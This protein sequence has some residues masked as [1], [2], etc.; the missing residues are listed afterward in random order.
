MTP[1]EARQANNKAILQAIQ[2]REESTTATIRRLT[3]AQAVQQR[4]APHQPH[5][6]TLSPT[7]TTNS[8]TQAAANPP[9]PTTPAPNHC[10]NGDIHTSPQPTSQNPQP[11]NT[12]LAEEGWTLV[13]RKK[14]RPSHQHITKPIDHNIKRD[15]AWLLQQRRCFKCFLKGHQKQQCNRTIKCLQCNQEGHIS[16]QC[17]NRF[18]RRIFTD[19][20]TNKYVTPSA[21]GEK[22]RQF[23]SLSTGTKQGSSNFLRQQQARL[24]QQGRC[25]K[26]CLRGHTKQQCTRVV[27]CF[28]CNKDGHTT[29]RCNPNPINAQP[30]KSNPR[31]IKDNDVQSHPTQPTHRVVN[32]ATNHLHHMENTS[33]WETMDLMDPD[34][35]EDG[36][37]ESLRVFLPPRTPL[38]PINSFLERSALVLAGPHPINRYIAHRLAVTLATHFNMQPQ[39]FPIS[40]VHQNYGDFLVRFPNT[41]LRDQAV[42]ICVFTLGPN[43]HLQLVEWTPGMG[44]VYDPVTHKARLRLYGLL[45]HNWNIHDL[46]ILGRKTNSRPEGFSEWADH[47]RNFSSPAVPTRE[48]RGNGPAVRFSRPRIPGN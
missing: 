39:D 21:K 9:P 2:K 44:G 18:N 27:K 3:Y 28:L 35:F 8:N 43:M 22:P 15:H 19:R 45:N 31:S 41:N 36:R 7:H 25:L 13:T 34:D 33:N 14:S 20:E 47:S 42:A 5:T 17:S 23:P 40:R 1:L 38:R 46:D 26:C 16:K 6:P 10:I 48:Q 37:R 30:P 32:F 29:I 24:L 11:D 4:R 12:T